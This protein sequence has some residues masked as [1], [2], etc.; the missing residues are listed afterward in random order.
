M[1]LLVFLG[2]LSASLPTVLISTF[3]V[4]LGLSITEVGMVFGAAASIG[5]LLGALL[6]NVLIKRLGFVRA[7][8]VFAVLTL[9]AGGLLALLSTFDKPGMAVVIGL[10][11]VAVLCAMPLGLLFNASQIRWS[12]AEQAGTDFTAMSALRALGLA[13]ASALAGPLASAVGWTGF[14]VLTGVLALAVLLLYARLF[15]GIEERRGDE[16]LAEAQPQA[17]M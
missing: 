5:G 16:P 6:G 12:S 17:V 4:D 1:G 3:L 13:V 7:A 11:L 8:Q 14:F 10:N 9:I 2:G 15:R